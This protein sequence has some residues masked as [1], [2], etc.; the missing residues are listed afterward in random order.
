MRQI[1]AVAPVDARVID[2]AMDLGWDDFE[3]AIVHE[4]ARLAGAVAIVTR[5]PRDYATAS[6]RVYSPAEF[7]AALAG[8]AGTEP[9]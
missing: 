4:N 7:C 6:L 8:K 9:K 2:A 5:N 1:L 3:D